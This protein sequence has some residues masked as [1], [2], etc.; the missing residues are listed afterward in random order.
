MSE[1]TRFRDHARKMSDADDSPPAE[2]ALWAQLADEID[3]Y[4][5]SPPEDVDLFGAVSVVPVGP[6]P[7]QICEECGDD[8][9][10]EGYWYCTECLERLSED[11]RSRNDPVSD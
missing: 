5:T 10:A 4:L 8:L 7:E 2:R 9:A 3:A 11:E 6:P 1:L